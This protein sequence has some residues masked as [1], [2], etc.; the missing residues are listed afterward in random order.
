MSETKKSSKRPS[1]DF[2]IDNLM[3][4]YES[5][6]KS[7]REFCDENGLTP[8][9]SALMRV[10]AKVGLFEAKKNSSTPSFIRRKLVAH[11]AVTKRR[12]A[13]IFKELHLANKV[14]TEDEIQV[15]VST[16]QELSVM[17]LGIDEDT[18]LRVVNGILSMRIDEKNFKPVT[19]GVVSRLI[20]AN[21]DLLGLVKGNS[22]DPKRVRQATKD[23]RNALFV[24]LDNY[25]KMLHSQGKVPWESAHDVPPEDWNNMDE[26]ATNAHDHRRK[27]IAAKNRL[28]RLFQEV[29]AGDNKMPFHITLCIVTK[30]SGKLNLFYFNLLQY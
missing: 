28:G 1:P 4:F 2:F 22:I 26:I 20:K 18:C 9:R 3:I 19:R 24:K 25:V 14:L 21:K 30:A 11:F 16:C 15:V 29:N 27:I 17:G 6:G 13:A 10:G 8:K 7:F 5:T 23:V 12:D